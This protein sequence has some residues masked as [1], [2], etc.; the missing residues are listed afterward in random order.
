[1]HGQQNIKCLEYLSFENEKREI[2][3]KRLKVSANLHCLSTFKSE[4]LKTPCVST[5]VVVFV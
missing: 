3:P 5:V 2:A 1:M 4:I